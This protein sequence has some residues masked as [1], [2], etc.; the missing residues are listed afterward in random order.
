MKP[1]PYQIE[2]AV[3]GPIETHYTVYTVDWDVGDLPYDIDENGE[4]IILPIDKPDERTQREHFFPTE[5]EAVAYANRYI[6][7]RSKDLDDLKWLACVEVRKHTT[8]V[9]RRIE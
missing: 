4:M 8:Q 1:V 5:E 2:V 3:P 6:E 7:E 9:L